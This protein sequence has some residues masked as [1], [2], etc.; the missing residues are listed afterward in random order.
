MHRLSAP[1]RDVQKDHRRIYERV[2]TIELRCERTHLIPIR[3]VM[4]PDCSISC[5]A[6]RLL[7]KLLNRS[8]FGTDECFDLPHVAAEILNLVEGVP[9]RH[10]HG[11]FVH[12]I[13]NGHR[14]VEEMLFRMRKRHFVADG[15]AAGR[16]SYEKKQEA[17]KRR[18]PQNAP[19]QSKGHRV[20]ASPTS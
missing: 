13:G 6:P 16:A 10:L 8:Y 1:V 9:R 14:H 17:E 19:A 18:N 2:L 15:S 11:N 3:S 5:D 7:I 20:F 12:D 4:K